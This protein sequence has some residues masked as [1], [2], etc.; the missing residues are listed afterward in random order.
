MKVQTFRAKVGSE[1]LQQLD[2]HLNQWLDENG[3][4]PQF[5]KQCFGYEFHRQSGTQEPV[6]LI[7]VWY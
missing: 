3:V 5:I 6:L 2:Q 7:T 4:T 1:S